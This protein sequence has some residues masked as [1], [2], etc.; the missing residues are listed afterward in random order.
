MSVQIPGGGMERKPTG[1]ERR[2]AGHHTSTPPPVSH[3]IGWRS[4]GQEG[5]DRSAGRLLIK[6]ATFTRGGSTRGAF[7][8]PAQARASHS[9]P[10]K[11]NPKSA[12]SCRAEP[13]PRK[14]EGDFVFMEPDRGESFA[15]REPG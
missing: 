8:L 9:P 14:M 13:R 11:I 2:L 4:K 5:R 15:P 6:V 3:M 10:P 1:K 7:S 12:A